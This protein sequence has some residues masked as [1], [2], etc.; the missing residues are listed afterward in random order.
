MAND[1]KTIT[2]GNRGNLNTPMHAKDKSMKQ[3][4]VL[5]LRITLLNFNP[6]PNVKP[7]AAAAAARVAF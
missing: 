6:V 3:T 2:L 5:D 7:T 4:A 1:V